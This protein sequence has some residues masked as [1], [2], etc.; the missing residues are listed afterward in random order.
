MQDLKHIFKNVQKSLKHLEKSSVKYDLASV[1]SGGSI[2]ST[3]DT[4]LI[5]PKNIWLRTFSYLRI[6]PEFTR[7]PARNMI[8]PSM[9]PGNCFAFHGDKGV[10][11]IQ[12]A[13][14]A[15]LR[16]VTIEHIEQKNPGTISNAPK[17]FSIFVSIFFGQFS[18]KM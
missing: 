13:R 16:S 11:S 10:V 9:A 4:N 6:I 2:D 18:S 1:V 7:N 15:F 17:L 12:L 3:Y 14:K 8:N 5:L